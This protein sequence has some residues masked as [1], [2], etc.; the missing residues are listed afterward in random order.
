MLIAFSTFITPTTTYYN[1]DN[2]IKYFL[3]PILIITTSIKTEYIKYFITAFLGG[4]FVNELISY[5]IYFEFIKDNFLGFSI[6]GN[7]YNPVPFL[8]SHIEYTQFLSLSIVMSLFTIFK[9]KHNILK[10]VLVIFL[11]TMITNLFLT[12]GRTGQ[13]TLL[14]TSLFLLIVYFK[15][16]IKYILYGLITLVFIFVLAFN[17]STNTN[18]RLKQGYTDIEN[19]IN[20]KNYNTSLGIRMTSYLII[21]DI[22]K[23]EN[24][25]LLYGFGY[26]AVDNIIQEIHIEKFGDE[27]TFAKTYGHLHNTYIS[28][29]AGLGLI[30]LSLFFIIWYY[31]FKLKI[32]DDY[33]N[34]IRYTFLLVITF[35]GFSSELFWQ[36]EIMLLSAMFI[37][38]IIYVSSKNNK[39]QING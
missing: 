38:I 3:L 19:F 2:F 34:Y 11:I 16:N 33:L 22:I 39:E 17:F 10:V 14:M 35:G 18:K 37:S 6:Y 4:M 7:K 12:T 5:G 23:N 32:E 20:K 21:P 28:I 1:Y 9:V 31:L 25:N 27:K 24:F 36:R 26:C 30:G 29:F 13:F 8:T 15:N